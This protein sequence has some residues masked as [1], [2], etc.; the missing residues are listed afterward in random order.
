MSA[1][2]FSPVVE[3]LIDMLN[4]RF[5]AQYFWLMNISQRA[6][7]HNATHVDYMINDLILMARHENIALI[8]LSILVE[9]ILF[10]DFNHTAGMNNDSENI[11]RAK[12]AYSFL[13]SQTDKTVEQHNTILRL[14]DETQYPYVISEPSSLGKYLRDLDL[15]TMYHIINAEETNVCVE[16]LKG[17]WCEMGISKPCL[18]W[19]DFCEGNIKFTQDTEFYTSFGKLRKER[20]LQNV[21]DVFRMVK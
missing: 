7:Y 18:T 5:E 6:P 1:N 3:D 9:A 10:H 2:K 13:W 8:N 4:L 19:K 11:A 20:T 16:Q 15:M 12:E 14:I 17:L 21:I